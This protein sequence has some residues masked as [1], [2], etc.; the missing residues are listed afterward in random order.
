MALFPLSYS[1]KNFKNRNFIKKRRVRSYTNPVCITCNFILLRLNLSGSA[2]HVTHIIT[3]CRFACKEFGCFYSTFSKNSLGI[4]SMLELDHF[5]L[6]CKNYLMLTYDSSAANCG[7][8]DL[9]I[10]AFFTLLAAVI[11]IMILVIHSFINAVCQR[12]CSTT[13]CV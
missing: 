5:V 4:C 10:I 7:D 12:K 9:L 11:Y 8:T 13:W 6:T 3:S 2:D 1:G